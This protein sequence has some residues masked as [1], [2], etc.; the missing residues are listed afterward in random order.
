MVSKGYS[1]ISVRISTNEELTLI[2]RIES[3]KQRRQVSKAQLIEDW[4][5]RWLVENADLLKTE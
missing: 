2:A 5:R 1:T 4:K 3:K